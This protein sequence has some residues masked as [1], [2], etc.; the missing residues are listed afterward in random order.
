MGNPIDIWVCSVLAS[1]KAV[2]P[3]GDG[4][5]SC[6]SSLLT[7]SVDLRSAKLELLISRGGAPLTMRFR[8]A[9]AVD[10]ESLSSKLDPIPHAEGGPCPLWCATEAGYVGETMVHGRWMLTVTLRNNE[11]TMVASAAISRHNVFDLG[12]VV[13]TTK[14]GIWL[15]FENDAGFGRVTFAGINTQSMIQIKNKSLPHIER[16]QGNGPSAR[17]A[18]TM[19]EASSTSRLNSQSPFQAGI[20]SVLQH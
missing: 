11:T 20:L 15:F 14:N 16:E 5:G 2:A 3:G 9:V 17:A 10:R 4:G 12:W 6:G 19:L 7:E 18:L 13:N 1:V 8:S